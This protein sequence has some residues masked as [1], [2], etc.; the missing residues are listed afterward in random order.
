MEIE[1]DKAPSQPDD[2]GNPTDNTVVTPRVRMHEL[3]HRTFDVRS[4]A[5]TGLFLLAL[6][7]TIYFLRS[8]LLPLVLALLL[9][10]LLRPIVRGLAALKIPPV[11]GSALVLLSLA[12]ALGYGASFL[13]AP[14]GG[15]I[16][17]APYSLH[18]LQE[19]L[20]A[21]KKPMA[22]VAQASGAIE[23]LTTTDTTPAKTATVEVKQHPFTDR[24]YA[25]TSDLLVSTLTMVILL[26]FMLAYDGVFL[27][28][29]IKLMP[30]LSDKKRAVTI[31]HEIEAQ[32]SRYLFTVTMIN[33]G[34]GLAVGGAVG[35]LGL[36]NPIMWGALVAVLN[37][38]PYLGA[39]TG[40]GCMLLGALLSFDRLGF[41]LIFPAIYLALA[42]I[43][44]NFITPFV[45]GRRLTLNPVL[46][47]LSLTFW[48][49]MWGIVGIL[50]AVPILATFKIFCTHLEPMEPLAEF[51][52]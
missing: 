5:M 39:L 14:V 31:A 9:S 35:F 27:V 44:G 33:V 32:I 30:T 21:F 25:H 16:E 20:R 46:V 38:I 18:Q 23:N 34:L 29:L 43:E 40:I 48:G 15:W 3:L 52:S 45:M 28:K 24:L 49:W 13:A 6:F 4:V 41:A 11:I 19:R 50:L 26:Y 1:L 17:K 7:Y 8:L 51:M 37:F 22:Q 47:L 2:A 10:Y 42:A 36:P 12:S